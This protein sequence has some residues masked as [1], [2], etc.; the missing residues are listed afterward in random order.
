MR[1]HIKSNIFSLNNSLWKLWNI[2]EIH[3]ENHEIL[4]KYIVQI[5]YQT[6]LK[7]PLLLQPLSTAL[8][9]KI[10][11]CEIFLNFSKAINIVQHKILLNELDHYGIRWNAH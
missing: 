5:I 3:C 7:T 11:T 4:C 6:A 8:D 10:I 9:M 2:I 1:N